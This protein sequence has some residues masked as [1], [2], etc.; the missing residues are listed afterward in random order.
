MSTWVSCAPA[1]AGFAEFVVALLDFHGVDARFGVPPARAAKA[2]DA[3]VVVG[4]AAAT[5]A[6][7]MRKRV[8]A[9]LARG[10]A[11]P[12]VVARVDDADPAKLV[13]EERAVVVDFRTEP[14]PAFRAL[15]AALG[16]EFLTLPDRR[17]G[18]DRRRSSPERRLRAGLWLAYQ[19]RCPGG[20]HERFEPSLFRPDRFVGEVG[21]ELA[22]YTFHDDSGALI[23]EPSKALRGVALEVVHALGETDQY[24]S[25]ISLVERIADEIS[26]RLHPRPVERRKRSQ[27]GRH[28]P[29]R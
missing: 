7:T 14:L 25:N 10:E 2:C 9:F 3:L 8:R 6:A 1:D 5:S 11:P 23:E 15:F 20:A 27:A 24:V 26:A 19:H 4:S 18:S 29:D 13:P 17:A 21:Q 28:A 16:R 12:I 22:R